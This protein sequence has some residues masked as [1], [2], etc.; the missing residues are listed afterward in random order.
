MKHLSDSCVTLLARFQTQGGKSRHALPWDLSVCGRHMRV[1]EECPEQ[2]GCPSAAGGVGDVAP[3]PALGP[4]QPCSLLPAPR[5]GRWEG[6]AQVS[7]T[8]G[9]CPGQPVRD[10]ALRYSIISKRFPVLWAHPVMECEGGTRTSLRPAHLI[11]RRVKVKAAQS[12]PL[13]VTPW[14]TQSME[15]S[16]P[17]YWRGWPFPS[18]GDLHDPGVEP[19]FPALGADSLPPDTREATSE[20]GLW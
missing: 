17:G 8:S 13:F 10:A 15:F 18:P 2:N 4:G 1:I 9:G 6:P 5:C 7:A 19:G 11:I 12:C 16:R 20:E 3:R 14:T